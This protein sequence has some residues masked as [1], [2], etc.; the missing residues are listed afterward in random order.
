[1]ARV[2]TGISALN[3]ADGSVNNTAFQYISSLTSNAQTQINS[4]MALQGNGLS[5]IIPQ[6]DNIGQ[7]VTSN[8]TASSITTQGN[9]FNE[10][11]K[12]L[13]LDVAGLIPQ[14]RIPSG[15]NTTKIGNGDVSNTM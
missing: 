4:K 15:I 2:K 6:F 7:A 1:L 9:E 12:L 11:S 3:I 13:L 8:I 5:G 10:P 14:D